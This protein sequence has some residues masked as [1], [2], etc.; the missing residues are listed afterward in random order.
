MNE[1]YSPA[2]QGEGG[3]GTE[4]GLEFQPEA[5]NWYR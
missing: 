5:S 2:R 3:S 4:S 1:L